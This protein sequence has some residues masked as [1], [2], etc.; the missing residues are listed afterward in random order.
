MQHE[1]LSSCHLLPCVD[2]CW[3]RLHFWCCCCKIGII[4]H[5]VHTIL[6]PSCLVINNR[7]QEPVTS[8]LQHWTPSFMV[9]LCHAP[10]SNECAWLHNHTSYL[11]IPIL[12]IVHLIIMM[13][14]IWQNKTLCCGL[15]PSY[16]C[17]ICF[18]CKHVCQLKQHKSRSNVTLR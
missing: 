18:L 13:V 7:V 17:T 4:S 2:E 10:V 3:T 12:E 6:V 14:N 15:F 16:F 11:V 5:C 1:I 8:S 9:P